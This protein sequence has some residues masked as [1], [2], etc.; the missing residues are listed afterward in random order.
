MLFLLTISRPLLGQEPE[1]VVRWATLAPWEFQMTNNIVYKK[2]NGYECKLDVITPGTRSIARPTLICIHGGGFVAGNKE[3][4]SLVALPYLAKGMNFVTVEYR[5]APISLA[6]AAVDDCR[7]ALRWV[8]TNAK[9][10]GF[11]LNRLVLRGASAGGHLVLMTGLV[12]A[13]AGFDNECMDGDYP[14][15]KVAAII[16]YFG[17]TDL[18]TLLH[19]QPPKWYVLRWLGDSPNMDELARRLSPVNYVR[20]G[21]P[22]VITIHGD[23]DQSV[24]Y[25]QALRLKEALRRAGVPNQLHTVRGGGHGGYSREENLAIQQEIFAFLKQYGVL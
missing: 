20:P 14:D 11:D 8:F 12:P 3:E 13:D 5:L 18:T 2:A 21:S 25:D 17:P 6:P 1:Q 4:T 10:Y 15:L 19:S 24:P 16:N 9:E 7:C 23:N 22:P